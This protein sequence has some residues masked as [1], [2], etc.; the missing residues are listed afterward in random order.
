MDW[1]HCNACGVQPSKDKSRKFQLTSCGHIFCNQCAEQN[2]NPACKVC[3][4]KCTMIQL[5]SQ[6]P[7]EIQHYF[8]DPDEVI[9]KAL[10]IMS[11]QKGHRLRLASL[12]SQSSVTQAQLAEEGKNLRVKL[13]QQAKQIAK[14][15]SKLAQMKQMFVVMSGMQNSKSVKFNSPVVKTPTLLSPALSVSSSIRSGQTVVP[16]NNS[17][18]DRRS[19]MYVS[20]EFLQKM[21]GMSKSSPAYAKLSSSLSG[22]QKSSPTERMASYLSQC[23]SHQFRSNN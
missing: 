14:L 19:P 18:A 6:M 4:T 3:G 9:K 2:T 7:P 1:I 13:V 10:Q 21:G 15:E 16:N 5:T 11:F 8:S 12:R 23:T 22:R 20:P 17:S